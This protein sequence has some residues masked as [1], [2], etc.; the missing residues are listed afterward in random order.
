MSQIRLPV[1]GH[2]RW[3][4][5]VPR[6]PQ[7]PPVRPDPVPPACCTGCKWRL[8]EACGVVLAKG[9]RRCLARLYRLT[10]CPLPPDLYRTRDVTSGGCVAKLT[11]RAW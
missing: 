3:R 8:D 1:A 2:V 7:T 4:H 9:I 11:T 5:A 6:E 10:R